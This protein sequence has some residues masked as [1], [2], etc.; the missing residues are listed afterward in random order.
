MQKK[1]LHQ[2]LSYSVL[3][4][5]GEQ[6]MANGYIQVFLMTLFSINFNFL[7]YNVEN[8]S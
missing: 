1:L 8:V 7:I 6:N 2:F 3:Y 4:G 5:R